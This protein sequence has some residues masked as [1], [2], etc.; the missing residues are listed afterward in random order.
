V[1]YISLG[2]NPQLHLSLGFEYRIEYEYENNWMFGAG[3]QDQDGYVMNRV[4]P[5]FDFHAG[6]YFRLFSEFEF[7]FEDGRNGD[8]VGSR[9]PHTIIAFNFAA[10]SQLCFSKRWPTTPRLSPRIS[11]SRSDSREPTV[12]FRKGILHLRS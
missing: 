6:T 2:E 10:L 4:M 8:S 11:V 9:A 1:K 7:D 3:P 5:H 12:D